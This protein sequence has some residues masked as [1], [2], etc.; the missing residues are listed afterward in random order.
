MT[1]KD[2]MSIYSA[3]KID[4]VNW[5][6]TL[7]YLDA[8][9]EEYRIVPNSSVIVFKSRDSTSQRKVLD[10]IPHKVC[11]SIKG[12][13][14]LEEATKYV[15]VLKHHASPIIPKKPNVFPK[16]TLNTPENLS[17]DGTTVNK[18]LFDL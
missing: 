11:I 14:S 7:K 16:Q 17:L 4:G 15:C 18:I 10:N 13:K 8:R 2:I 5:E 1:K 12:P 9:K 6:L 3:L